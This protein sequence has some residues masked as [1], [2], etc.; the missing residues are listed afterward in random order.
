MDDFIGHYK[1][2]ATDDYCDRV[3]KFFDKTMEIG[4]S[5][6]GE[7]Y[8]HNDNGRTDYQLLLDT[9]EPKPNLT[10]ET[11]G[12][13]DLASQ[14][15]CDRYPV[16]LKARG[17]FISRRIKVQKTPIGGGFHDWHFEATGGDDA[18]GRVL[19]WS[20]YLNDMPD[21]EGET[22]FLYYHKRIKP[23]KG[24][25]CIFPSHFTHTH[26][27]NPPLTREKYI[28]TGWWYWANQI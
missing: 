8:S 19:V 28:A 1:N 10:D 18:V 20:I 6:T 12:I 16:A 21:G 3:V 24:D 5:E 17:S 4:S 25:V 2:Y 22:E 23:C 7:V 27:G 26:R 13:L 14:E 9:M 15:Y 11:N